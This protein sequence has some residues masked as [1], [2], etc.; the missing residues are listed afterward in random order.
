MTIGNFKNQQDL[1]QILQYVYDPDTRRLRTDITGAT[2]DATI[3]DVTITPGDAFRAR[4]FTVSALVQVIDYSG[5]PIQGIIIKALS[6][7]P[8]YI[9]ILQSNSLSADFYLLSPGESLNIPLQATVSPI[10][11]SYDTGSPAG[12]Y[13]IT[14]FAVNG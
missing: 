1:Q 11:F 13:K 2:I 8:G 9:K 6:E 3:G 4:T 10:Y 14:T 5:F 7:N 12:T